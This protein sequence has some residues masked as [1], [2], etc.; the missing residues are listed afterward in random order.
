[1]LLEI[2]PLVEWA[3]PGYCG[4]CNKDL[5]RATRRW[6]SQDCERWFISNHSWGA[7]RVEALKRDGA[8]V[9]CG[10]DG[11]LEPEL[12]WFLRWMRQLTPRGFSNPEYRAFQDF[13][14]QEI[15]REIEEGRRRF[16]TSAEV[17]RRDERL[18]REWVAITGSRR[19]L[20]EKEFERMANRALLD[21][22]L[23]VNH[24][25]PIRGR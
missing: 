3:G 25:S 2:C 20:W 15:R 14:H 16:S 11:S 1:R 12:D 22:S 13:R 23:E 6:C 8:C 9:R 5:G 7:A 4:G 24:K 19:L 17:K 21:R 18:L 10:R